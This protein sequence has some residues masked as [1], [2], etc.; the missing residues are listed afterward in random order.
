MTLAILNRIF[1]SHHHHVRCALSPHPP[2]A[3]HRSL[4]CGS[5]TTYS[6]HTKPSPQPACASHAQS[7][8]YSSPDARATD[9]RPAYPCSHLPC[10]QVPGPCRVPTRA[11]SSP[12][13][14]ARR[15][16][17]CRTPTRGRRPT[18][19]ML[20]SRPLRCESRSQNNSVPSKPQSPRFQS[21]REHSKKAG[22]ACRRGAIVLSLARTAH[23]ARL[24][25]GRRHALHAPPA[26]RLAL[27][28][29]ACLAPSTSTLQRRVL[30]A[31]MSAR[32][33]FA[34]P[35]ATITQ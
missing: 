26:R 28:A 10:S 23:C 12:R 3:A 25:C 4:A 30:A 11:R 16:R 2:P 9:V 14:T 15:L 1:I 24:I 8:A 18:S 20:L 33:K 13:P 19:P 7:E 29:L 35:P 32:D 21:T 22:H 5:L 34:R 27:S 31:D 6:Y 17:R